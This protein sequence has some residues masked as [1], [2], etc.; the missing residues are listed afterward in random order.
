MGGGDE[1]VGYRWRRRDSSDAGSGP[2]AAAAPAPVVAS[3]AAGIGGGASVGNVYQKKKAMPYIQYCGVVAQLTAHYAQSVG[4]ETESLQNKIS[5][6]W[7]KGYESIFKEIGKALEPNK[8]S[9]LQKKPKQSLTP[10]KNKRKNTKD[11]EGY[12]RITSWDNTKDI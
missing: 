7:V 5:L 1:G 10:R 9:T 6:C 11:I 3:A 12:N 8:S 2:V 4:F